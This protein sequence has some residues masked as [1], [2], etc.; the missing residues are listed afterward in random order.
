MKKLDETY[1]KYLISHALK[2]DLDIIGDITTDSTIRE[3]SLGVARLIA[4]EDGIICGLS[5][6]DAVFKYV[7]SSV[8]IKYSFKDGDKVKKGDLIAVADGLL[9]SLLKAERTALNFIQRLSG[10]STFANQLSELVKGK[11]TEILDTRKTTPGYRHLEK[12]AVKVGGALNHRVGLFDMFLIKENHIKGAGSVTEAV[13]R[14]EEYRKS[15]GIDAKIEVEVQNIDMFNE[16]QNTGAEIIMLDNMDNETIKECI[17]LN[18][19]KKKLEVSGNL[20]YERVK[21]LADF[22]VDFLSL[23]ALTHS[24]K[25]FDLSLLVE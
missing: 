11:K 22:G 1:Y 18:R 17:S 5:I 2:E 23:G 7:D 3:E 14:A 12:Y 6:F 25:S 24:V 19:T 4:K 20:D 8:E 15:N 10:I 21:T 9:R 13:R 16:A